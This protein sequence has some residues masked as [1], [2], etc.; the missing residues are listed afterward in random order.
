MMLILI[1]GLDIVMCGVVI[2][3]LAGEL[4]VNSDKFSINTIDEKMHKN[5]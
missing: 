1:H 2:N 3:A 5:L 4:S